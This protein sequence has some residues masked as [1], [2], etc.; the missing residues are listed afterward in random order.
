MK[1]TEII[2]LLYQHLQELDSFR[3]TFR[4]LSKHIDE[5]S[6]EKSFVSAYD[7]ERVLDHLDDAKGLIW[8]LIGQMGKHHWTLINDVVLGKNEMTAHIINEN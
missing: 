1:K 3:C 6:A 7:R 2:K 4:N 8:N 5:I